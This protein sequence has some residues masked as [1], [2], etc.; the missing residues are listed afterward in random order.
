MLTPLLHPLCCV[1]HRSE[2]WLNEGFARY[3]QVEGADAVSQDANGLPL[4]QVSDELL[5]LLLSYSIAVRHYNDTCRFEVCKL[6]DRV[7]C[8]AWCIQ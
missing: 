6:R 4:Y 3:W 8:P 1:A 5:T 7:S 2:V